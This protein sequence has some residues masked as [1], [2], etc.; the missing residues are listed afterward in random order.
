M[1][2]AE[3]VGKG[4]ASRNFSLLGVS[5]SFDISILRDR[6]HFGQAIRILELTPAVNVAIFGSTWPTPARHW[7]MPTRNAKVGT[8]VRGIVQ[9]YHSDEVVFSCYW[10]DLMEF[11]KKICQ[12][13][14]TNKDT[15]TLQVKSACVSERAYHDKN[16]VNEDGR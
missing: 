10:F 7:N 14:S 15:S 13:L 4:T 6:E 16:L 9:K 12:V 3:L 2:L 1:S 5:G 8:S 11:L